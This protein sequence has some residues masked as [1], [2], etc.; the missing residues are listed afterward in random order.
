M[1]LE[2]FA[3]R[4]LF[5]ANQLAKCICCIR[6]FGVVFGKSASS[7]TKRIQHE[8][9]R[10]MRTFHN[11]LF[12]VISGTLIVLGLTFGFGGNAV[13]AAD[14]IELTY[15]GLW[16]PSHPIS[17]A[18]Q[19]WIDKIE[20]DSKGRVKI[21][22]FWAGALFK[23][24]QSAL[25]LGKGVADIG[26]FSGAYAPKGFDFEKSFRMVFWGVNDRK[27]ARKIYYAVSEKYPQLEEE[28]TSAGIKVMAYA[29][30]PPYQML[31][32]QKR[33]SKVA[34]F[35]GLTAKATGDLGKV[36]T[37]LGGEG[38]VMPMS[39][40][41]TALQKTT[42]DAVFAPYETL[43]SFRF[44]EVVKYGLELNI[45]SAPAGHWGFNMKSWNN[46]P[47]DIQKIFLDNVE[48]FGLKVEEKVFGT[49]SLGIEL[50]KKHKVE[51][52]KLP[53]AELEKV[54]AVVDSTIA[55]KMANLD[56]KGLPGTDVYK[57]IRRLIKEGSK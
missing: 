26:D 11:R 51:F 5:P 42:I 21:K 36:F 20:K 38:I 46:L 25:E 8:R 15:G 32:A 29:S 2:G 56:S 23:P 49:E 27:L 4:W 44:A 39:E 35:K 14:P 12:M 19:D 33:V 54:Y 17:Q 3:G 9:R 55:K 22:P 1:R 43:K 24:R 10:E 28:F 34:D 47:K 31:L 18:T 57:E 40:S 48:W 30:I 53:P 52:I 45:A 37:A 7:T 41:Y 50:A 16:P 13:K 6:R